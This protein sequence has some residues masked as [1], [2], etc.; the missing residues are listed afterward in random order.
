MEHVKCECGHVNPHGTAFCES[1]GKPLADLGEKLILDMRYEGSARRSQTYNRTIVDQIW[2]F[3]SSVKVGVALIVITLIA[4]AVGTI[5]PQEMYI[6]P[7]VNPAEYYE[8]QYG[9]AGKLYYELGFNNLYGSWWYILLIALIGVSLVI[10]SLDRVVP[11][12]RALKRQGVKRHPRFLERQR[13]FGVSRV[14]DMDKAVALLKERLAKQRYRIREEGGHLLAEKGRFSR[15]G[16]YVNHVGLIIF[17]IGAML[18]SV[19]GMYI[20]E[21]MWIREGETKE[22]PGTDGQYFLKSE[23][24]IFDTYKKGEDNEVFNAAIDR[25]GDGMIAENYQTNVVLYK[26]VDPTVAGAKPKLEKVKEYS[27]RVNEPLK[28]NH[29]ALYQVDFRLNEPKTMSFQLADKQSGKTFGTVAIDLYDPKETYDLGRGYRVELL[30]YFPDFEF[31]ED[32]NPSTKSR[33][34]NNP[35][36]VFKMYAPD[37]PEGEVSFVAIQQTIEPFGDNKYKMAFAGLETRNVSGLTV[38]RDFTLWILGVGGA[39]FMIGLIQGMY[40]NHRR[41]WVQRVNG[42]LWIA[43]HTNKN[44]FGLKNE[45]RR[46]LDGTGLTM[47][48]DR[49]EE[50]KKAGQGGQ[51]HGTA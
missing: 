21:V 44:W 27:I 16:P 24:F 28:F 34:P 22:I 23:K 37:R 33:V 29:Y 47:P 12:Y 49:L 51:A 14:G 42:E 20:D 19:P 5:F 9:W 30:S 6:P 43:A 4:S 25:V 41:I 31:D 46:L 39:I 11:L 48:A 17:L 38:R 50:E 1:C 35:A 18:R 45:L 26:R 36:F 15:W 7:N 8:E 13:L 3:F 32:G 10:C 2:A 40:W